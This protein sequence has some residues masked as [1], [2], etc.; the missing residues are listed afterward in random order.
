MSKKATLYLIDG[1]SYIFRAFFGVRQNLS[2]SKGLPTNALYGFVTMLQRVVRDECPDYL[3]VTFDSKEKTFRHEMYA[4]YKAN[5]ESP[6]EDLMKQ[7][8]Y[9][10]RLVAAHNIHSIRI[11]GVEADDIIGTLTKQGQQAGLQ[12][13][14][15]SGDKDMMQLIAPNVVMLDTMKGKR[16]GKKEVIEKFGVGPDKVIDVMGLMGDSS[17]NIPGV[18]GVGPKTAADL[19]QKFGSIEELYQRIEEVDKTKLKDKLIT[20]KENAELSRK[21]VTID[22]AVPMDCTIEDLKVR[23]VDNTALTEIFTELEFSSLIP[24]DKK[25]PVQAEHIYRTILTEQAFV[26]LLDELSAQKEFALDM[27]T[28]SLNPVAAESVGISFA[29][30]ENEAY[31]IPLTHRY[32]GVP[33]QLDLE[34]VFQKLKPILEDPKIG[35]IGHNIKYDQI[36]LENEGIHL[37]GIAFDTILASYVLDP[38]RRG[39]GMDALALEI[40]GH[41]TIT[42]KEVAGT[43]LKQIGFDEVEIERA[44]EYAAEDSDITWRLYRYFQPK[45]TGEL[46]ALYNE[47]EMPLLEVLA[48]MEING[49]YVDKQHLADLSRKIAKELKK[50]EAKIYELAGEIFNI[51]SPKQL[52]VIL[53]EK[54]QLP[55]V[56]KTKT[57]FSTDVS[58]LE[59]LSGQHELPENILAF[60][61]L[62]KL[63]STYVDALPLDID[64]KTGRVHT[65]FNQTVAATGR[66]SS[67]DPNLQNIPIRTDMGKEIRKAF[68]AERQGKLLSADYSQIELRIL[69]HLSED[70]TLIN[71]FIKGEDIH[72]RTA[73]EIFGTSLDNVDQDARRMAKAVNFGIIYGLSAFGLSR[74]LKISMKE[75]KTFI[76]Q[77]FDLYPRIKTFMDSAIAQARERGYTLTIM[78]RKRFLPDI[79]SSNKQVRQ[80]AER[81]AINSP[82][83]GSAADIIKVAMIN[84]SRELKKH[85]LESKMILQVHDELVFEC[86]P[87]EQEAIEAL[88]KKEMEGVY[89]FSVPLIVDMG[90]GDNWNEAH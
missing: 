72:S 59:E 90:W 12:V 66:L 51:N 78:N 56:K 28:T 10:E 4:D 80:A 64:K 73:A 34:M 5:R 89:K 52:A 58:V 70:V 39:H 47:V 11:P 75:A 36:V 13:V 71:A 76:D 79:N 45:L 6:P 86:P 3:T 53:F 21:L 19:I 54:L 8:P 84:L 38:S 24:E 18:K 23:V 46:L 15:V 25:T 74:Q 87:A 9:F 30:K 1:S 7:F 61:Q 32:L 20:D 33:E 85:K 81:I 83:Q 57:G 43:G 48:E 69:A 37:K 26:D 40:F 35:K 65:S 31:Y 63:K 55:V 16:F 49:V 2:T 14:I 44:T 62:G 27:E 60:R 68:V 42:Y 22:T 67:S 41:R 82:I 77:Y 29:F 50:Y 88:V 17:D